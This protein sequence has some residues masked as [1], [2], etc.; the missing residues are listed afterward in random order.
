MIEIRTVIQEILDD[1][2][3]H[4]NYVGVNSQRGVCVFGKCGKTVCELP[5]LSLSGV[6]ITNK[7]RALLIPLVEIAVR[8]VIQDITKLNYS[9][10]RTNYLRARF[11]NHISVGK[12]INTDLSSSKFHIKALVGYG[13]NRYQESF[14]FKAYS[15]KNMEKSIAY[16]K[17]Y[18]DKEGNN[19]VGIA[20]AE[21]S[22]SKQ[23]VQFSECRFYSN[24]IELMESSLD[25]YDKWDAA[26]RAFGTVRT[27]L[28]TCYA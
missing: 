11:D 25:L 21:L 16:M 2:G 17:V 8:D 5:G 13:S 27:K 24:V 23:D 18:L 26:N 7:E 12:D 6:K 9:F 14:T 1:A 3:L 20:Y 4:G 28:G 22:V 15:M 10:D 19:K